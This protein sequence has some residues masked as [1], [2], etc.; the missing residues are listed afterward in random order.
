MLL[1]QWRK[2]GKFPRILGLAYSFFAIII[3]LVKGF[4]APTPESMTPITTN[5]QS[6][7]ATINE[8]AR[9]LAPIPV[10][11]SIEIPASAPKEQDAVTW[12]GIGGSMSAFEE[13]YG[14]PNNVSDT[15]TNF[16]NDKYLCITVEDKCINLT[17]NLTSGTSMDAALAEVKLAS[18]VDAKEVKRYELRDSTYLR[19]IV[20]YK[21]ELLSKSLDPMWF[22]DTEPGTFIAIIKSNSEQGVFGLVLGPG[23]NP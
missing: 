23:N 1:L 13:K 2:L 11:E 16:D 22:D 6:E 20:V 10:E 19:T 18:P 5:S 4:I 7:I 3:I 9:E 21:S 12:A 8:R 14:A 17:I 15:F